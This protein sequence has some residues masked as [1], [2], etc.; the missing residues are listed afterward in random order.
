MNVGRTMNDRTPHKDDGIV[1]T[2]VGVVPREMDVAPENVKKKTQFDY[3]NV[4][5]LLLLLF[6]FITYALTRHVHTSHHPQIRRRI[7]SLMR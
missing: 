3:N 6:Y 5:L 7:P 1:W 4:I 2:I